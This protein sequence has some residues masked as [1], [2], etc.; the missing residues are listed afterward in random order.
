M[1]L[2]RQ[3]GRNRLN[4]ARR[5]AIRAALL[6][7]AMAAV[8]P[9]GSTPA[10]P[11]WSGFADDVLDQL[12][13]PLADR[14][15]RQIAMFVNYLTFRVGAVRLQLAHDMIEA[16]RQESLWLGQAEHDPASTPERRAR[17]QRQFNLVQRVGQQLAA[18]QDNALMLMSALA[19]AGLDLLPLVTAS[20]TGLLSYRAADEREPPRA[21]PIDATPGAHPIPRDADAQERLRQATAAAQRAQHL[22]SASRLQ[23][24]A[25]RLRNTAG[26]QDLGST[27]Q[28]YVEMLMQEDAVAVASAH[29]AIAWQQTLQPGLSRGGRLPSP[30]ATPPAVAQKRQQF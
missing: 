11:W 30:E 12:M 20:R 5:T 17:L 14:P 8:R 2:N 24:E 19:P 16:F 29:L 1:A 3:A 18:E 4:P 10:P 7:A 27:L 13:A 23:W 25:A 28:L 15:D 6:L 21:E 22:L 9:S 26:Q